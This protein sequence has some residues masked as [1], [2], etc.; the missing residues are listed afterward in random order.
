MQ[1]GD[2]GAYGL[3]TNPVSAAPTPTPT[4]DTSSSKVV[5]E[6]LVNTPLIRASDEEL[7]SLPTLWKSNTPFGLG[8]E[9]AVCAF[10]RHYG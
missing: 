4:T 2:N 5:F 10:L 9:I 6:G 3:L 7:V 8:D 1:L